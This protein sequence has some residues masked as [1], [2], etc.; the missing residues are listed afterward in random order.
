M[1]A[2]IYCAEMYCNVLLVPLRSLFVWAQCESF[3][4]APAAELAVKEHHVLLD[5]LAADVQEIGGEVRVG[6]ANRQAA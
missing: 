6:V 5:G 2:E 4:R 1:D 3:L